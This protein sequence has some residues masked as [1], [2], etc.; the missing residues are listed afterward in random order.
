MSYL[1]TKRTVM[2]HSMD[3]DG[4]FF[5]E[6][7]CDKCS[8]AGPRVSAKGFLDPEARKEAIRQ[9]KEHGF[10]EEECYGGKSCF[11]QNCKTED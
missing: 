6:M 5:M 2:F 9:A 10:V 8:T 11:C 4:K 3:L 7:L 1:K